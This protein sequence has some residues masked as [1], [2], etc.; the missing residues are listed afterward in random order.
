MARIAIVIGVNKPQALK[1]LQGAASDALAFGEWIAKQGFD[2]VKTFADDQQK[3][4]AF[5]DI[6]AEVNRVVKARTYSQ[7]VIYFA[8]HGFQNSGSEVWLLSG[9]PDNPAEAISLEASVKA[10]R[11]SGLTSVVFIS[12]A[13]RSI[14][15]GMPNI[16]VFGISIFPN[17]GLNSQTRP[18]VDR[19]LATLPSLVAVEAA[20]ADD[21]ARRGG[22]FTRKFMQS[23][24][25]PPGN[26]IDTVAGND[27]ITNRKLKKLIRDMVE[28]A[29]FEVMPNAGQLP[30]FI[31][32]SDDAYV[33]R[34]ERAPLENFS[35]PGR[36]ALHPGIIVEVAP[37]I[38]PE[39]RPEI[40]P[41]IRPDIR[42]EILP[43]IRPEIRPD[44]RSGRRRPQR[45][46]SVAALAREALDTAAQGQGADAAAA[47]VRGSVPGTEISDAIVRYSRAVP[48]DRFETKTGFSVTGAG[49]VSAHSQR[50]PAE[51][52]GT[53]FVRLQP[54]DDGAPSASV[55][56]QFEGGNGTVLPGL[57]GYI[58]HIFVDQGAV[59]N[60]NYVP[61]TNNVERWPEYLAVQ[62]NV[63]AL[64]AAVAAAAGLG[65]FRIDRREA[66]P[67]ADKI[68]ELKV[69]DPTLGLYAAYAYASAGLEADVGSVLQSMRRDL[70]AE[71]FDVAMLARRGVHPHEVGP[72]DPDPLAILPFCPMLR[73]GW[74]L[75]EV[76]EAQLPDAARQAQN[77]LLPALWS[78]FAPE[79]VELLRQAMLRGDFR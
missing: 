35:P 79:G 7:L 23:Y 65:V 16:N 37:E 32:E 14:P 68:R 8:G 76:C 15:S 53:E 54:E 9:A 10:A 33:G 12:D 63:E 57:R 60:V 43:E 38:R 51:I 42:P 73:Q 19:L 29:A 58:G 49:V 2:E 77:W 31:V 52:L 46:P 75:L 44:I 66:E 48:R 24:R 22:I 20:Q 56:I 28:D 4:V 61:S 78:T 18:D 59:T 36:R 71:L 25:D 30:D 45:A 50:F 47:V 26:L 1:P 69:F 70:N 74:S 55:L 6:F 72:N 17:K 5:G 40:G 41:E 67:F 34:V 21:K 64:R 39:V 62:A 27:V 13:C 3:A 11:E